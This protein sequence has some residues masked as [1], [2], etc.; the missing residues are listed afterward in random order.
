MTNNKQNAGFQFVSDPKKCGVRWQYDRS[1]LTLSRSLVEGKKPCGEQ[2]CAYF[3]TMTLPL[4]WWVAKIS[5]SAICTW[6]GAL[7]A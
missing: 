5:T 3:R 4:P 2:I 6:V 1:L 7:A